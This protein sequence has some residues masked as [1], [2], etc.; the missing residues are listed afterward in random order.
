MNE[1]K[2]SV[3]SCRQVVIWSYAQLSRVLRV[4]RLSG[5]PSSPQKSFLLSDYVKGPASP[6][7]YHCLSCYWIR[8]RNSECNF[9]R[10]FKNTFDLTYVYNDHRS[11]RICVRSLSRMVYASSRHA[12][13]VLMALFT[14]SA[15]VLKD[16]GK[17][18]PRPCCGVLM[19]AWNCLRI[20]V[21]CLGHWCFLNRSAHTCRG[22]YSDP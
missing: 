2:T 11:V 19:K 17:P 7:Y 6:P 1:S 15:V 13:F 12:P 21:G 14:T 3:Y 5:V 10:C 20:I 22:S 9:Q 4:P 18:D 16:P 8:T